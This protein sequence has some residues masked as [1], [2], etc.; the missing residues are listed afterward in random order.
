MLGKSI[1]AAVFGPSRLQRRYRTVAMAS[2][3]IWLSCGSL[4]EPFLAK[5]CD[6]ETCEPG[7]GNPD[8]AGSGDADMANPPVRFQPVYSLLTVSSPQSVA[9]GDA[10][11]V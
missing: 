6:G 9:V 2:L 1:S 4:W 8:M 5:R 10:N 3:F 11:G 7:S